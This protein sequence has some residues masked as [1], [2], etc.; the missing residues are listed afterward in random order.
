MFLLWVVL[1]LFSPLVHAAPVAGIECVLDSPEQELGLEGD[2]DLA[3]EPAP[4]PTSNPRHTSWDLSFYLDNDDKLMGLWGWI[5]P[6]SSNDL[7][8]THGIHFD[9]KRSRRAWT[10]T[11]SVGTDLYTR[12][13]DRV[14]YPETQAR[15]M[16]YFAGIGG[17]G[18]IGVPEVG[19]F[20]PARESSEA[21]SGW[22]SGEF[23]AMVRIVDVTR[24]QLS[25]RH[26]N[27]RYIETTVGVES[28]NRDPSQGS[29][30]RSIQDWWH[31]NVLHTYRFDYVSPR[32]EAPVMGAPRDFQTRVMDEYGLVFFER[33]GQVDTVERPEVP[34]EQ[35]VQPIAPWSMTVGVRVGGR[36]EIRTHCRCRVVVELSGG[37]Q[38]ETEANQLLGPHSR[39]TVEGGVTVE[40][41]PREA[42][43]PARLAM[44]LS[45]TVNYHPTADLRLGTRFGSVTRVEAE[46]RLGKTGRVRPF[47]S[48]LIPKGRKLFQEF[49]DNDSIMRMGV[50]MRL[51]K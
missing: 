6:K 28:R 22:S 2:S 14:F 33:I 20:E 15:S 17:S 9:V 26:G 29:P 30:A 8:F 34:V 46:T 36:E 44:S 47:F 13:P 11:G 1:S 41:R 31:G 39:A 51:Q 50:R 4:S 5:F 40:S 27:S 42:Q 45:Q 49:N 16:L 25:A 38:V 21:F 10:W 24:V 18:S 35:L 12:M 32:A 19:V 43:S 48:L 23:R 7:G 3:Q 37:A